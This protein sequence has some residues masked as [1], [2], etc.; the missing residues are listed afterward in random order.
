MNQMLHPDSHD[1]V[2]VINLDNSMSYADTT[3]QPHNKQPLEPRKTSEVQ[4]DKKQARQL[5]ENRNNQGPDSR[6]TTYKKR[7][8]IVG[9]S[10]TKYLNFLY[11][12]EIELQVSKIFL[13]TIKETRNYIDSIADIDS[14]DVLVLPSLCIE[15]QDISPES[16]TQDILETVDHIAQKFKDMK[17]FLSLGLPRSDIAQNRKQRKIICS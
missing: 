15:I 6:E 7:V 16:C 8:Q 12:G 14:P 17:M 11:L 3:N 13:Y 9:T 10:N 4:T 5:T 2:E 1:E